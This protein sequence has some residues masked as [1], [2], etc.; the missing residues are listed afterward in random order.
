[1]SD[2]NKDSPAKREAMEKVA[3]DVREHQAKSGK[4]VWTQDRAVR[5]IQ[6]ANR[7]S[8]AKQER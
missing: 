6:G 3:R 2:A 5:E 4:P 8:D 1:M 7:R